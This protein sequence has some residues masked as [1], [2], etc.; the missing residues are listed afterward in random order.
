M[1]LIP[2]DAEALFIVLGFAFAFETLRVLL[3]LIAG[4]EPK[5]IYELT[6]ERYRVLAK[7]ADIKS[8][9]VDFVANSLLERKKI[10]IEKEIETQK[11]NF[12]DNMPGIKRVFRI[13][14]IIVYVVFAYLFTH[15]PLLVV[16]SILFWPYAPFASSCNMTMNVWTLLPLSGSAFR[17]VVRGIVTSLTPRKCA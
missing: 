9:Q 6:R 5:I 2:L 13:I 7:L 12:T 3:G 17:F 11:M 4:R 15:Q 14:R 1:H 16:D 8:V 10:K